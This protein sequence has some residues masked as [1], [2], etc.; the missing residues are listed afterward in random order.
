LFTFPRNGFT[1]Y[2]PAYAPLRKTMCYR[3]WNILSVVDL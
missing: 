1:I 3:L 2:D